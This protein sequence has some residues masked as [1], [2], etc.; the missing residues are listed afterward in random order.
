MHVFWFTIV[1]WPCLFLIDLMSSASL[2]TRLQ[3]GCIQTKSSKA[4]P[5][6]KI[7][8]WASTAQYGTLMTGPRRVG[9]WRRTGPT[10][11]SSQPTQGST[12]TR[13]S[14]LWRRLQR[15]IVSDAAAAWLRGASI[16]GTSRSC[17]SWAC[18]RAISSSGFMPT[19]S[20]MTTAPTLLGSQSFL[21]SATIIT[22]FRGRSLEWVCFW[23][24]FG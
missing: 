15:R 19:I 14:A 22:V 8:P 1:F 2:W 17:R 6:Q 11:P 13:A 20:S 21:L 24:G 3:F 5:F 4:C 7:S 23:L 10:R 12:L 16:G 9:V 18:I